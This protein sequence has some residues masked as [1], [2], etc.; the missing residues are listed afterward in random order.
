MSLA[1]TNYGTF[2]DMSHTHTHTPTHPTHTHTHTQKG[3]FCDKA[4][5]MGF[6]SDKAVLSF[7]YAFRPNLWYFFF[8]KCSVLANLRSLGEQFQKKNRSQRMWECKKKKRGLWIAIV[9]VV[10]FF[11]RASL[12][13]MSKKKR[14]KAFDE[15]PQNGV[16]RL[17]LYAHQYM[18]LPHPC[19]LWTF[20]KIL[21]LPV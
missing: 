12:G 13:D 7:R 8:L 10:F 9:V 4:L 18:Y 20:K 19:K 17:A 21:L 2:G 5:K 16:K 3:F 1:S 14:Q 11:V 15:S 6:F